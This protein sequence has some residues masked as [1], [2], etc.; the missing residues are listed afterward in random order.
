MKTIATYSRLDEAFL[1]RS[2]LEGSGVRAFIP[3][4]NAN[5]HWGRGDVRLMVEDE[6]VE[7]AREVLGVPPSI[8]PKGS[9]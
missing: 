6:D 4:E 8:K 3:E 2:R 7:R 9:G 1:A 5:W